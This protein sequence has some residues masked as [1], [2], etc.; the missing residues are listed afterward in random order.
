ME[1]ERINQLFANA[2]NFVDRKENEDEEN[3]KSLKETL[4]QKMHSLIK[5][6]E[7][8]YKDDVLTSIRKIIPDYLYMIEVTE[9]YHDFLKKSILTS[10]VRRT[11]TLNQRLS[12]KTIDFQKWDDI[13]TELTKKKKELLNSI[14]YLYENKEFTEMTK[15][16]IDDVFESIFKIRLGIED[17]H[18]E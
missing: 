6:N 7:L 14:E 3:K 18:F 17:M 16:S 4:E 15:D 1:K 8:I 9:D 5:I 2:I 10:Y 13:D 12:E 11:D